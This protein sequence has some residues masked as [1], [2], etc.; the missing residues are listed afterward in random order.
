MSKSSRPK[1]GGVRAWACVYED[2]GEICCPW[3]H[4]AVY[5]D[6]KEAA[7]ARGRLARSS[8]ENIKFVRVE[9]RILSPQ[10]KRSK[11]P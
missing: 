6:R 5:F 9:I 4:L 3:D 8:G 1:R 11:K 7:N 2:G 10:R